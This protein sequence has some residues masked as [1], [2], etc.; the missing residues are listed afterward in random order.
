M[1]RRYKPET[2]TTLVVLQV[3]AADDRI[4]VMLYDLRQQ[5]PVVE[6]V[7]MLNYAPLARAWVEVDDHDGIY[8]PD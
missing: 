3:P 4:A 7:F 2:I 8:L 1:A 6:R 5:R